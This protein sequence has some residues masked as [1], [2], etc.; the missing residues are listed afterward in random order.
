MNCKNCKKT[1][2]PDKKHFVIEFGN[3]LE[4]QTSN[5]EHI[6]TECAEKLREELNKF[7]EGIEK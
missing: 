6:C 2:D 1:I 4:E 3:T 5:H 7:L